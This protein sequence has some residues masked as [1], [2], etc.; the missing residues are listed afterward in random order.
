MKQKYR[1]QSE[2]LAVLHKEALV[3]YKLGIITE[4]EMRE[5]DMDCLV[6]EVPSVSFSA[7]AA[8]V[9]HATPTAAFS[10]KK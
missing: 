6:P 1:Y 10:A 9:R 2:L 4:A 3:D 8:A 7:N 5:Y